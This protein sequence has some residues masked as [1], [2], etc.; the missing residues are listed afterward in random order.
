LNGQ[1]SQHFAYGYDFIQE[2]FSENKAKQFLAL[3]M[4]AAYVERYTEENFEVVTL[5]VELECSN[6]LPVMNYRPLTC[7][8]TQEETH[9]FFEE[10]AVPECCLCPEVFDYVTQEEKWNSIQKGSI[11]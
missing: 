4:M 1:F 2:S 10:K 3:V 6:W 7:S 9:E 8:A 11:P 5:D